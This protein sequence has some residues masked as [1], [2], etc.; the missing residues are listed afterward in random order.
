VSIKP[1]DFGA[2]AIDATDHAFLE[3]T[4][5][6]YSSTGD[7]PAP[8]RVYGCFITDS[9]GLILLWAERFPR[10][11]WIRKGGQQFSLLPKFGALSEFTG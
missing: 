7:P 6:T 5:L 4:I 10:R 8:E 1:L 9:T 3:A 11:L 2:P